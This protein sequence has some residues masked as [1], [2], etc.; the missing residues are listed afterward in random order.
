MEKT[1]AQTILTP[2]ELLKNW[3]GHRKLTRRTIEA[4]PDK[5]LFEFSI[6]GMRSFADIVK[7]L[8]AIAV[9]GL[10]EIVTG[11][12]APLDEKGAGLNTKADL[13]AAWD[14]ANTQIDIYWNQITLEKFR[15]P[16]LLF[17]QYN[18][19]V[20]DSIYYF[21]DNEIHHRAQ[22]YVYLRSLGIQ[23]PPFWER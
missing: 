9:P 19:P 14:E 20:I 3:Q 1:A 23:P 6:G 15:E 8:L 7:E 16:I 18:A 22:G 21:I 17:G 12:T 4:F 5:E 2:A 10:K 13:L 11:Q